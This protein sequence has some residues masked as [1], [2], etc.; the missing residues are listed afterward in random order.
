MHRFPLRLTALV[1]VL[2]LTACGGGEDS[3]DTA[4]ADS[5]SPSESPSSRT[6]PSASP[7]PDRA[8][9]SDTGRPDRSDRPGSS[10]R[11]ADPDGSEPTDNG[12]EPS[13]RDLRSALL[14]QSAMPADWSEVPSDGDGGGEI[15]DVDIPALLGVP[16]RSLRK[17]DV[18]YALDQ[19]TGPSVVESIG[20]VPSGRAPDLLDGLRGALSDCEGEEVEGMRVSVSELDFATLGDESAAYVIHVDTGQGTLDFPLVYAISGDLVMGVYTVDIYQDPMALLEKYAPR[21]VD[22]ALRVLA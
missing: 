8:R 3:E 2:A 15:C 10:D 22:K 7:S 4:A 5:S 12:D 1:A 19:D 6:D 16:E 21:A 11:G 13:R 14:T 18:Q 9:P 17:A 20:L